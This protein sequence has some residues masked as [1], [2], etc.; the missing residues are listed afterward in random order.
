MRKPA[1]SSA[2]FFC[3]AYNA[4]GNIRRTAEKAI[5]TLFEAASDYDITIVEAGSTDD[6]AELTDSLAEQCQKVS[7]IHDPANLGCGGALNTGFK[8]GS[9][10]LTISSASRC[11]PCYITIPNNYRC[12]TRPVGGTTQHTPACKAYNYLVSITLTVLETPFCSSLAK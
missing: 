7:V 9:T 2:S 3:P 6:T 5:S 8:A 1:V 12:S 11:K 4:Q 10:T